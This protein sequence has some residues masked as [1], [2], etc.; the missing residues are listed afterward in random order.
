MRD[1][2]AADQRKASDRASG[3]ISYYFPGREPL[4]AREQDVLAQLVAGASNKEAGI[5]LGISHRTVEIHRA[6]I[7]DKL[8]AICERT[9]G[10]ACDYRGVSSQASFRAPIYG[11]RPGDPAR[12]QRGAAAARW[13]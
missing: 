2:I 10:N 7:M 1:G 3:K 4:T 5:Q 12:P 9:C 6:R 11:T 13:R 8:G